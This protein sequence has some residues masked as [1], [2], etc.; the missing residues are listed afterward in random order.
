MS[1]AEKYK[2][3][4]Y[5]SYARTD[6]PW[7]EWLA[8]CL[9][10]ANFHVIL[11]IW[12][13]RPGSNFI[14]EMNAAIT[15]S[16]WALVILSPNYLT[17]LYAQ[18][19]WTTAFLQNKGGAIRVV[20]VIVRECEVEG[21]LANIVPINI[22][23]L[24]EVAAKKTLIDKLRGRSIKPL[25]QPGYPGNKVTEASSPAFPIINPL[26]SEYTAYRSNDTVIAD[27][28]KE[29]FQVFKEANLWVQNTKVDN[30]F[31]GEAGEKYKNHLEE[32]YDSMRI[33]GMNRPVP[34]RSIYTRVNILEK[35]S[36]RYRDSIEDLERFFD[37]DR[38]N[39]GKIR[40]T[41]DGIEVINELEKSIILGKPGAGKTTF[42]KY[43]ALQAL[44]AN[45]IEKRIPIFIPV[46]EWD[47]SRKPLLEFIKDQFS[48]CDFPDSDA[49]VK[50]LLASGS[51]LILLDGLDEV[52]TNVSHIIEQIH[53]I[54]NRY[55]ANKYI[56]SCRIAA[57]NYEFTQFTDLELADFS[58]EQIKSFISNWFQDNAGTAEQ[59]WSKIQETPPIKEL[60]SVPLLLT[61][62]CLAFDETL[63][64]PPNKAELYKD[65]IDALLRKWD[66]TRRIKRVQL[67]RNFSIRRKE[68]M[69]SQIAIR[70]FEKNHYFLPQRTLEEYILN[71]IKNLPEVDMDVEELDAE[72]ILKSIEHQHGIFIERAKGIFSFSHLTFQEYFTA[73]YLV[74][75]AVKDTLQ[76]LVKQH[77]TDARWHEIFLIIA[78]MLPIGDDFLI[79]MKK[80]I[81][82]L[83]TAEL[84]GLLML[85]RKKVESREEFIVKIKLSR[86]LAR[87]YALHRAFEHMEHDHKF[88]RARNLSLDAIQAVTRNTFLDLFKFLGLTPTYK[89]S[90]FLDIDLDLTFSL[91]EKLAEIFLVYI[92]ANH[93][94][95]KCLN[96]ECYVTQE[97]RKWLLDEFLN[98]PKFSKPSPIS[99][100]SES[101]LRR[102]LKS[103]FNNPR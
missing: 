67:Y 25:K 58:D 75:N 94:L 2:S 28:F 92:R 27:L 70:T 97:T 36:S 79:L 20:P 44:D 95:V 42:L 1:E 37:R 61:L 35:I 14:L 80:Q 43:I 83:V 91:H 10:D 51:C 88:G 76:K 59:C 54:S 60:A 52:S 100:S 13:F 66:T 41:K 34:L 8:W 23:D 65:S 6:R 40:E 31:L 84:T 77:L 46:K 32:R 81:D 7:A 48:I 86:G 68:T 55:G 69:F 99:C 38:G 74:E 22:C 21:L 17:S 29:S 73:K 63:T 57:Y 102:L 64:F 72:A 24:E 15:S 33:F 93:L 87:A 9:E 96:S 53:S 98:P 56:I 71:F 78:G 90:D 3:D 26:L 19:Q 50:R 62:L 47:D 5:I 30:N 18:S 12:N 103:I 45:L 39:F 16:R 11:D 82:R 49:F 4:F 85:I 101:K 89:L